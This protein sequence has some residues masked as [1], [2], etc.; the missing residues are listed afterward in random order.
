M[1]SF[2]IQTQVKALEQQEKEVKQQMSNAMK[3]KN[4]SVLKDFASQL[5]AIIKE[6]KELIE[7]L[8]K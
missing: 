7:L 5:Q 8:P 3:T 6:K 4:F 1:D 2:N